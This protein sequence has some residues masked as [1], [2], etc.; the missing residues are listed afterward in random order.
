MDV[1]L[2]DE[3]DPYGDL[4]AAMLDFM[5]EGEDN[6][7]ILEEL[8]NLG[9]EGPVAD[10]PV[11]APIDAPIAAPA[12]DPSSDPAENE[13]LD[14]A[15]NGDGA[16]P[17]DFDDTGISMEDYLND[18]IANENQEDGGL[19]LGDLLDEDVTVSNLLGDEAAIED[20]RKGNTTAITVDDPD[21][22][23]SDPN[24]SDLPSSFGTTIREDV[25]INSVSDQ[26]DMLEL[27]NSH[28][29]T[30]SDSVLQDLT[31]TYP[32]YTGDDQFGDLV[33]ATPAE[34]EEAKSSLE[35]MDEPVSQDFVN[36]VGAN[37]KGMRYRGKLMTKEAALEA[38]QIF[39]NLLA[40]YGKTIDD[41]GLPK[42]IV[43]YLYKPTY[44]NTPLTKSEV[45]Q[46]KQAYETL[47]EFTNYELPSAKL[48]PAKN[49]LRA[50]LRKMLQDRGSTA[51]IRRSLPR[52]D[53]RTRDN[54]L[55]IKH[56]I[57]EII[58]GIKDLIA[59]G[60]IEEAK[61]LLIDL[62]DKATQVG[63]KYQV[64]RLLRSV[65]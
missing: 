25:P 3:K 17:A 11:D 60:E 52:M 16:E 9:V 26:L 28:P 19:T 62:R 50:R 32:G 15:D 22:I 30:I 5:D 10:A 46:L 45:A 47:M 12:Y 23:Y 29:S 51:G 27:R 20:D 6:P 8:P 33:N 58:H 1:D 18:Q 39:N 65:D 55:Y 63:L 40:H 53:K 7:D 64:D 24:P 21:P 36:L 59:E 49:S 2:E 34:Q 57:E 38:D 48:L 43:E 4:A 13:I 54:R 44:H 35:N 14:F 31:A 42:K 37:A 61:K 56:D 41:F